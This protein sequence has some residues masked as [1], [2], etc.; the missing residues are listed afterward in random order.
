MAGPPPPPDPYLDYLA[1]FETQVG[2]LAVGAYGKFHGK[3]VRKL[4]S[5]EFATRYSEF[6]TLDKTYRGI[7]ERGDTINDAVVRMWR[8]RRA[9]L[10]IDGPEPGAK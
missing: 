2:A 8:E 9:E 7:L 6:S 3:L 4:S 1:K 5:D 10:L